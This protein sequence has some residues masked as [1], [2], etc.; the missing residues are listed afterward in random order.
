M[1]TALAESAQQN[2]ALVAIAPQVSILTIMDRAIAN[3]TPPEALERLFALHERMLALQAVQAFNAAF[4][5]FR[6]ECP[7]VQRKTVNAFFK[8]VDRN[9]VTVPTMYA[10]IENIAETVDPFLGKNGLSYHWGDAT[11]AGDILTIPFVLK[12]V[13]GHSV[14]SSG[15]MPL[16]NKAG[17][18]PQ[19]KYAIAETYA[20]RR[21]MARGLGIA[22][23]DEDTDGNEPP[24]QSVPT[25]N[26]NQAANIKALL[27]ELKADKGIFLRWCGVDRIEDIPASDF[28]RT[29]DGLEKK[30]KEQGK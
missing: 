17:C 20:M 18:S 19:Q 16:E 11:I 22:T 24:P 15:S 6:S 23:C 4:A 8:K 14:S 21:S 13:G 27:D 25:I 5:A 3:N 29:I 1:S 26:A 10:S 12:H 7:P 30:R 9:G 28:K 2:G